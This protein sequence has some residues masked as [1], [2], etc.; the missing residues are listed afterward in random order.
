[1]SPVALTFSAPFSLVLCAFLFVLFLG[2][3]SGVVFQSGGQA[4][5]VRLQRRNP[6]D[7]AERRV[8]SQAVDVA[9]SE[10]F[11]TLAFLT[12]KTRIAL[13]LPCNPELCLAYNTKKKKKRKKKGVFVL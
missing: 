7:P 2:G 13:V 5:E 1:M 6:C 4:E 8:R 9:E 10:Q 12:S 3:L 11:S